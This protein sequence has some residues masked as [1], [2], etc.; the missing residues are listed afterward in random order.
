MPQHIHDRVLLSTAEASQLSEL[1][2]EHIQWLLRNSRLEGFKAGHDWLVFEDSLQTF[3]A[4]TRKPG[5]KPKATS[6]PGTTSM[7][8]N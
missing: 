4:T 5:P 8:E 1:S 7:A 3:L 2:Q 6:S